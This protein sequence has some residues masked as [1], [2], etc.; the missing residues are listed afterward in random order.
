MDSSQSKRCT[1][2]EMCAQKQEKGAAFALNNAFI[3][4]DT[5]NEHGSICQSLVAEVLT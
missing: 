5:Q 2:Q 1:C 3:V 4:D